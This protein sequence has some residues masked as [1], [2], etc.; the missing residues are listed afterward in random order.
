MEDDDKKKSGRGLGRTIGGLVFVAVVIG[1]VYFLFFGGSPRT[2]RKRFASTYTCPDERIELRERNDLK[3]SMFAYHEPPSAE[4]KNDPA[5]YEMFR[6]KEAEQDANADSGG[7]YG[8]FFYDV[9]GCGHE[10][11]YQCS[12]KPSCTERKYPAGFKSSW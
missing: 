1:G 2:A 12:N 5:R 8:V 7:N 10:E 9:R 4:V 3:G 6:K 11:L